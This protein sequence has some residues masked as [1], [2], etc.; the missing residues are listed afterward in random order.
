V[1][2]SAVVF[3]VGETLVDETRAW[4]VYAERAG[5]TALTFFAA[6][7][8]LI[9]R[10][11]DHRNVFEL[12]AIDPWIEPVAYAPEDLYEDVVPC[13]AELRTA[14]YRIGLAGNQPSRTESFLHE[15]GLDADFL[16][17]SE[18]WG[19]AKPSPQF[20][21]RVLDACGCP[22]EQIAYVGDR[23]D[24]DVVPAREA[25]MVAV[26]LRRGPWGHLQAT[27]PEAAL[28]DVRIDALAELPEA[29]RHV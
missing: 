6:L 14:G 23:V 17:S 26:F 12:L 15:A 16:A 7:G 3:D 4:G 27:W 10:R 13:L 5:V 11:D 25:G 21:A 28:A 20:F 1:A 8:A 9:E 22:A 24:N 19:V 18:T 29:L 2:L